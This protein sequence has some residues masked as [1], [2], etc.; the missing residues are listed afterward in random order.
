VRPSQNDIATR[1]AKDKRRHTLGLED[2]ENFV[3]RDEPHLGD[4]VLV[5]QSNTDR[6][7]FITLA[8]HLNDLLDDFL[9]RRF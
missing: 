2:S 9:G 3:T 5:T 6:R 7:R 4:A 8:R 1:S